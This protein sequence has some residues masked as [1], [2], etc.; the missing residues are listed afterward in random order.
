MC[1]NM[2][3]DAL[4]ICESTGGGVYCC[5]SACMC[6]VCCVQR[7]CFVVSNT[8]WFLPSVWRMSQLQDMLESHLNAAEQQEAM[9]S[10]ELE[11]RGF[12]PSSFTGPPPIT[13]PVAHQLPPPKPQ[14]PGA[15]TVTA[16]AAATAA[17]ELQ[18]QQQPAPQSVS[19]PLQYATYVRKG[20]DGIGLMLSKSQKSNRA[21]IVNF[22]QFPPGVENPAAQCR[23][24]IILGY[25][26]TSI[27]DVLRPH[28]FCRVL[29]SR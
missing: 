27:N 23:P 6:A 3:A 9:E 25:T 16:T 7:P 20:P 2:S 24:P 17:L 10:Y 11:L 14:S 28:H 22:H 1:I 4:S 21:R 5:L 12:G 8:A 13:L 15:T 29:Y 26:I 19:P 18:P